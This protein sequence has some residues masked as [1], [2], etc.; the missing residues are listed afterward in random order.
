MVQEHS[1]RQL[2]QVES[3]ALLGLLMALVAF[4]IDAML[5]AMG[6]IAEELSAADPVQAQLI[7]PVFV[8]GLGIGTLFC[9]PAS[10][11]YG[12]KPVVNFGVALFGVGTAVAWFAPTLEI[13]LLGRLIQGLGASAARVVAMAIIRDSYS[14]KDMAR[15]IS[16]VIMVFTLVPAVAPS[17]GA[18]I[19]Y[20]SDWRGIFV[21]L[22]SFAVAIGTWFA[23]RQP[24]TLKP[25]QR[26]PI[27]IKS[28]SGAVVE[29]VSHKMVR[30][31]IA[32]QC[33][34]YAMLFTMLSV[35][36]PIFDKVLGAADT[37]HLWFG[38]VAIVAIGGPLLNS[39]L[40]LKHGVHKIVSAVI[41]AQFLSCVIYLIALASGW[42]AESSIAAFF[43]WQVMTF[44]MAGMTLGNLNALA[45]EPMGHIAG[46]ASSVVTAIGTVVAGALAVPASGLF[47]GSQWPIIWV[48]LGFAVIARILLMNPVFKAS[49]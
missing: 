30:N 47:N 7:V 4:S 26:Q 34:C 31:A 23:V 14:G 22:L 10:D 1:I 46:T 39:Q 17:I 42:V 27:N 15:M 5:P 40:V 44:S 45:L 41:T 20:L 11:T 12:R 2:N 38:A 21:A 49:A 16:F 29:V 6:N 13:L 35:T 37:F 18:A 28:L 8:I 9:G 3:V 25:T 24:E 48:I 43:L 36:Q 19:I 32:V 33:L